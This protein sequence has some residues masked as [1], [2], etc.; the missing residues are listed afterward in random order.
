[1]KRSSTSL[2]STN[3]F[4][5]ARPIIKTSTDT[6]DTL[7]I[8][9]GPTDVYSQEQRHESR[10]ANDPTG[11]EDKLRLTGKAF[12]EL[13]LGDS[14][15][16]EK[17]LDAWAIIEHKNS[18]GL[19]LLV[20][21]IRNANVAATRLLL[22]K[23]ADAQRRAQG[24]P[25]VFHAARDQEHGPM[26][27]PLLLDHGANINTTCGLLLQAWLTQQTT[28]SLGT[29]TL[30]LLVHKNTLPCITAVVNRNID[31]IRLLLDGGAAPVPSARCIKRPNGHPGSILIHALLNMPNQK[32]TCLTILQML[33]DSNRCIY[34]V[35]LMTNAT[36]IFNVDG[37][38]LMHHVVRY[39]RKDMAAF[40]LDNGGNI[41]AQD[42]EERTPFIVPCDY[43]PHM[44]GFFLKR[45]ADTDL[46]Y[47]DGRG[48][49]HA[50]ATVGNFEALAELWNQGLAT[51][52]LNQSS[53]DGWTPLAGALAADQENVAMF[54]ITC[55]ANMKHTIAANGRTMLHFASAFG[56]ERVFE[57]IMSFVTLM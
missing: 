5:A 23:E 19:T 17:C 35:Q 27:I 3:H 54:L 42:N 49:L 52:N 7:T 25:P 21:A 50:A 46:L 55:G 8:D 6:N 31:T 26:L 56:H 41:N 9:L 32:E 20:T 22:Q 30:K 13:A 44:V 40:P 53:K 43:E 15:S 11:P 48:P 29:S 47:E 51:G 57:H 24:K 36:F 39:G 16:L 45:G 38:T 18:D 34:D 33:L 14:E 37:G 2:S 4:D 28:C 12:E 1:M 10:P